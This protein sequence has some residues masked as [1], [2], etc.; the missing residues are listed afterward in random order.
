MMPRLHRHS[1]WLAALLTVMPAT[2]QVSSATIVEFQVGTDTFEVNLYD[3][4]TPATVANF[5]DYVNSDSYDGSIFHRTV[6]NFIVQGGGFA[7][8]PVTRA[9]DT[10]PSGVAV[11]N[12]PVYANVRGTIAMAKL[13][14]D[15]NSA[16]NQW[17]FNLANNTANLDSQNG[18]FT[19]FGE[20]VGGGMAVVDAIAALPT[21][22]LGGALTD[23][24]LQG[25]TANNPLDDTNYIIVPAIIISDSTVDSAGVAG[26]NP[27]LTTA[28]PSV[29]TTPPPSSGG[30]GFGVFALL[31]LILACRSRFSAA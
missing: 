28:T 18:G 24:P 15:P 1:L 21:F 4:A 27:Q 6:S 19:V 17:F 31:G 2:S 5:L 13:S 26:L 29:G 7:Y 8:N 16:T 9:I 11:V 23:I 30:G 3:N 14:G 12:E 10:I 22:N 20:V 25:N